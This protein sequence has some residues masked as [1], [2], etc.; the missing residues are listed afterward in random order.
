M[1]MKVVLT[2]HVVRRFDD[3]PSLCGHIS[4][5]LKPVNVFGFNRLFYLV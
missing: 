4:V 3:L 1:M 2:V 5:L